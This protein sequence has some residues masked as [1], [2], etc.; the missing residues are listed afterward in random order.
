MSR[1]QLRLSPPLLP[2]QFD[3]RKENEAKVVLF[4]VTWDATAT[5]GSFRGVD[6]HTLIDY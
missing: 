4:V 1:G 6:G 2:L 5:F 3:S